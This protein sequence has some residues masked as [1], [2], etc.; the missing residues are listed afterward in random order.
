MVGHQILS[1]LQGCF[2]SLSQNAQYYCQPAI[3]KHGLHEERCV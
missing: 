1:A 3:V 2:R